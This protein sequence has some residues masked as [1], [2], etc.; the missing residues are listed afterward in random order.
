MDATPLWVSLVADYFRTTGDRSL[1]APLLDNVT[2][3]LGWMRECADHGGGFLRYFD[4][5][6]TGLAN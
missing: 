1:V 3:A 4:E 6:G 2:A 5:S